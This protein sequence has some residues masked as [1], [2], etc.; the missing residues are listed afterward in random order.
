MFA[1]KLWKTCEQSK[2][3]GMKIRATAKKECKIKYSKIDKR[4]MASNV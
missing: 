1:E 3:K 4:A 2:E